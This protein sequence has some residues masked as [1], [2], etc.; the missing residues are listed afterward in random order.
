MG[1]IVKFEKF[2][3]TQKNVASSEITFQD[4]MEYWPMSH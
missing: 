2:L 3:E 4:E 1:K